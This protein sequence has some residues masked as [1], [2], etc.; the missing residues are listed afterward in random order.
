[1]KELMTGGHIKSTIPGNFQNPFRVLRGFRERFFYVNVVP[2]VK[3]L[4]RKRH[5][6]GWRSADVN[7]VDAAAGQKLG[8]RSEL[9]GVGRNV[10]HSGQRDH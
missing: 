5:M 7:N 4:D 2:R 9:P 1:V 6:R 10:T 8:K 3:R